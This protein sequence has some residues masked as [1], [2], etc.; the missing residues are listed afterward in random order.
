MH[1]RVRAG[2]VR[3]AASL[4]FV[5]A[6]QARRLS[7]S[8]SLRW[9]EEAQNATH[10]TTTA[11]RLSSNELPSALSVVSLGCRGSLPIE[12]VTKLGLR[13]P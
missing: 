1:G 13:P 4:R 3:P 8:A 11:T 6:A 10:E 2:R 5:L 9:V 12:L 7:P